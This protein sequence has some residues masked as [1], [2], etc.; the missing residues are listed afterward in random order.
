MTCVAAKKSPLGS[1]LNLFS[2]RK[3]EETGTM[4][5]HRTKTVQ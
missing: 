3:I 2:W 1:G 5:L 4:M